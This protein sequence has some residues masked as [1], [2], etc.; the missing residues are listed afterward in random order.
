MKFIAFIGWI[1]KNI[2]RGLVELNDEF[3]VA[4][5][6]ETGLALFMWFIVSLISSLAVMLL[7]AGIQHVTGFNIPVQVWFAYMWACVIYLIYTSFS[8]MYKAFNDER[9]E[10]F[11]TIKN[12]R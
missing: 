4:L 6:R 7:L 11:N 8:L 9:A 5:R 3:R 1:F 12:G 2:G 10:I